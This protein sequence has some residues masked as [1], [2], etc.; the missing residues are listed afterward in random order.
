MIEIQR[1]DYEKALVYCQ[2]LEKIGEKLRVG[3][4]GPFA[5]A[6]TALCNYALSD[7]GDALDAAVDELRLADAK[8]RLAYVLTRAG[9]LDCERGRMEDATRRATEALDHAALLRRSTEMALARAVLACT[10]RAAGN[11]KAAKVHEAAIA[12]LQSGG[13]AEW[14]SEYLKITTGRKRKAVK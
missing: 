1:R 7:K 8:H 14:A 4:E 6:L 11:L 9:Q 12:E 13:I 2:S 10:C 3:S 5:R